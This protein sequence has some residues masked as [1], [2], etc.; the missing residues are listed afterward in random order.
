MLIYPYCYSCFPATMAELSICDKA[1]KVQNIYYL[2]LCGKFADLYTR[3]A[4]LRAACIPFKSCHSK[5]P[6]TGW[7]CRNFFC[8]SVEGKSPRSSVSS[9]G[10]F[11]GLWGRICSTHFS[12]LLAL[13]SNPWLVDISL[14]SLPCLHTAFSLCVWFHTAVSFSV[15]VFVSLPLSL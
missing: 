13:A 9:V 8:H 7:L 3:E 15:C 12:C 14:Q 4:F 10:S 5:I 11:W 1:D 6:Q 2:V